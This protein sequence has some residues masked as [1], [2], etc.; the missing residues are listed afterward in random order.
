MLHR[1]LRGSRVTR[2]VQTSKVCPA[3]RYNAA[4]MRL[5]MQ[6]R[7]ILLLAT[8][9]LLLGGCLP[10]S[11]PDLASRSA[12]RPRPT[13]AATQ[14]PT[15]ISWSFWGDPWAVEVNRRVARAFEAE[16]PAIKVE[17]LHQPWD[18]YFAWLDER[19][20]EGNLPDVMFYSNVPGSAAS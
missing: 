8:V 17:L 3:R 12:Q 14:P 6:I 9:G 18:R 13:P 10:R 20:G 19:R 15:T 1:P 4:T 11:T 16:H 5:P 2:R 7:T